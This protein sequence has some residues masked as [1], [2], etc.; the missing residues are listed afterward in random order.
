MLANTRKYKLTPI[1]LLLLLFSVYSFGATL[2]TEQQ[3]AKEE[4]LAWFMIRH[5]LKAIPLLE[6]A[7][8]A[9][10]SEAQ[11]YL[12]ESLRLRG[13][14][15]A[16]YWYEQAAKQGDIYAMIRLSNSVDYCDVD[17]TCTKTPDEWKAEAKKQA[18]IRTKQGDAEA[19]A[20]MYYITGD[21]TWLEKSAEAGNAYFQYFLA[22][23]YGEG[24][25]RF[26]TDKERDQVID[27]WMAE[28]ARNGYVP[29]MYNYGYYL[30]KQG[31]IK[32]GQKWIL[33]AVNAGDVGSIS[34]YAFMISDDEKNKNSIFQF[35]L[36]KI[37]GYAF[38]KIIADSK[39]SSANTAE[40]FV[41]ILAE[42]MTPEEIEQAKAFAEEWKK[43][44]PPLS[45]FIPKMWF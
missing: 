45:E 30:A 41:K 3:K 4:G 14:S 2:T 43:T 37:K 31:K 39:V 13:Q 6:P 27:K 25:G 42:K 29:A 44:H 34:G 8:K 16:Y 18:S 22:M 21:L 15:T 7:A 11:Y 17:K 28:S 33:K 23:L 20:L 5:K 36:D 1:L 9:G 10:D 19:M 12:A 35:P 40:F 38:N 24:K 32:E 26:S